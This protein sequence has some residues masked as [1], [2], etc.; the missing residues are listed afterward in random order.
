MK[1]VSKVFGQTSKASLLHQGKEITP[2]KHMSGK[3]GLF[4]II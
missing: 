3:E 4:I 1:N 2:Y